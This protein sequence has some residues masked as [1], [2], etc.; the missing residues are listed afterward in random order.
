MA[1]ATATGS[2]KIHIHGTGIDVISQS[3]N[4]IV[5]LAASNGGTIHANAAAY[6]L[7]TG[8]GGTVTRIS[9]NGGHVH[10]PYLW[11]Q[12]ANPPAILSENGADMAVVT[13][14]ADN[15]PHLVIYDT[16]C[17]GKWFDTSTNACR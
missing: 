16:S 1:A 15:H 13:G 8:S 4:N 6:S 12:H 2:G 10:A 17:A 11:E 9:N 7:K 14:T 5:A 3:A